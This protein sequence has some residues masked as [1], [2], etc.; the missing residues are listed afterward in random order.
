M[1]LYCSSNEG[2]RGVHWEIPIVSVQIVCQNAVL[3]L[4]LL[5]ITSLRTRNEEIGN[6]RLQIIGLGEVFLSLEFS[7]DFYHTSSYGRFFS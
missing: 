6:C 7:G 4:S 2:N 1:L 3:E 5:S